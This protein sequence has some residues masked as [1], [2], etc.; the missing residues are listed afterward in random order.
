[1]ALPSELPSLAKWKK[2]LML[3]S[4]GE[5]RSETGGLCDGDSRDTDEKQE[6]V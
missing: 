2:L 1:M 5:A 6:E 4:R 3:K